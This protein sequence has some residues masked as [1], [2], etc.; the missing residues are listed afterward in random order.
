MTG[1]ESNKSLQSYNSKHT[2]RSGLSRGEAYYAC[3][4]ALRA[5]ES[6]LALADEYGEWAVREAVETHSAATADLQDM[7]QEVVQSL[8]REMHMPPKATTRVSAG[9][10]LL[11]VMASY[12]LK[13]LEREK[14]LRDPETRQ[15]A[16]RELRDLSDDMYDLL[17]D[18]W[19]REHPHAPRV[20]QFVSE[21]VSSPSW[22][23][24]LEEAGWVRK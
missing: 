23:A 5:G 7:R 9:S 22:E 15:E 3:L 12:D 21:L 16:A 14:Q 11:K 2:G 17:V 20:E 4:N 19:I 24:V 6:P 13:K 8:R 1:R 10:S 18:V